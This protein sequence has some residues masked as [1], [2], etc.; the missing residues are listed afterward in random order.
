MTIT[1]HVLGLPRIGGQRELKFALEKYWRQECTLDELLATAHSIQ[2]QNRQKQNELTLV[3]CSDF[4]F[5][6]QILDMSFCLGHLPERFKEIDAEQWYSLDNYFRV[7]RGRSQRQCESVAAAEMTKWFNSNYHYLV[8]EFSQT[9]Q[10][11]LQPK[12]LAYKFHHYDERSKVTLPGPVTYLWSGKSKD[13]GDR[14]QL[15]DNLLDGYVELLTCLH[16]EGIQWVQF[17][18]PVLCL[19]LDLDW[20][21][22]LRKAYHRLKL[23]GCKLILATYFGELRENLQLACELPVQTLHVDAVNGRA[24]INKLIDWLPVHKNLSL[25]IIDGR[26]IWRSDLNSWLDFL[27]PVYQKMADRLWL[28]SSC[29]LQHVPVST[30]YETKLDADLLSWLAF[31]D[32]KITELHI[33]AQALEQGREAFSEQLSTN[34]RM[35]DS[36]RQ[37]ARVKRTSVSQAMQIADKLSLQRNRPHAIR[38]VEQQQKLNLPLFPTT[39]IGSFPQTAEIRQARRGYRQGEISGTEYEALMQQHIQYCI[40]QQETLGLDVLVHGEPERNDMVEFFAEQLE[41]YAVTLN[42]WVQSYGSRCVKPPLIYGDIARPQNMTVKWSVFAQSCTSQWVKGMLTGPVT[43]LNWSFVRDDQPLEQTCRQLALAVREEVLALEAA[44]ICIIQIDEAALREGM[45]LRRSDWSLYLDW[46]VDAFRLCASGVKDDTQIHTH[47]CYSEFN[48]IIDSI[49]A[50]DADVITIETSRSDMELLDI[51]E[52][53]QY[54]N[55]IGPGVYDIH[56]PNIPD[57]EKMVELMHR[58][59]E[60]IEARK[61]WVNPDCGLKTRQWQEV[62]PALSKMVAAA[63]MLREKYSVMNQGSPQFEAK[64]SCADVFD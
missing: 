25:G 36:R 35:V 10:F 60:R 46:A 52:T 61:L 30:R 59:A 23:V 12:F 29:S 21:Q 48:E 15:L 18:E 47:M 42:G 44:G 64:H 27:Q 6:D 5:Y 19:E 51:F 33:L 4:S 22:A 7:A 53:R 54:P 3:C 24:E 63:K 2:Q 9:D 38:S 43:M 11:C 45:P 1:T 55:Q 37:H 32:E 62:L 57:Q 16:T 34:R 39:T 8:P 20:Q 13:G 40:T 49:I 17:D 56:N 58:A 41:G 31:A 50:L 14:L 28:A 26:N